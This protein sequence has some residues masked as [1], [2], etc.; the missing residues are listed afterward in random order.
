MAIIV[1]AR[2][3]AAHAEEGYPEEIVGIMIGTDDGVNRRV[4]ELIRVENTREENRERRYTIDPLTLAKIE[5]DT[6]KRGLSVLGFYHSHPDHPAKPSVT[7]LD[8]AWPYYSYI[9]QSV[10]QGKADACRSWRLYDD[11]KEFYEE[12]IQI[13]D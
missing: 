4:S 8:W 11:R 5:R 6:A 3:I 1:S 13:I 12:E 2:E 10:L 7:D 9:I